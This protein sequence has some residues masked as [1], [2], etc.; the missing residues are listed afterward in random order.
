MFQAVLLLIAIAGMVIASRFDI[1]Y[2]EVPYIVN[3]SLIA[4]GGFLQIY[5]AI[6]N[7]NPFQLVYVG[8]A[9]GALFGFGYSMYRAGQW[10]GGDALHVLGLGITLGY[11]PSLPIFPYLFLIVS[12]FAGSFYGI[13]YIIGSYLMNIKEIKIRMLDKLIS[14]ILILAS[15]I[16]YLLSDFL[17]FLMFIMM[18]L[19]IYTLLVLKRVEE[20]LMIKSVDINKVTEG[21]WLVK[22]IV[23]GKTRVPKRNIGLTIAD[24]KV[25]RKLRKSG[26]LKNVTIKYGVPYIPSFL[27]AFLVMLL[28]YY[29]FNSWLINFSDVVRNI[30]VV[31]LLGL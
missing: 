14:I 26:R 17:I 27:I 15:I 25:L 28:L 5:W 16:L 23:V 18:F 20:K 10:G 6:F 11:F 21:D 12:L 19:V 3:F 7:S 22:A 30:L 9:G 13:S 29:G 24:I 31:G 1:K 8:L 4:M 2:R